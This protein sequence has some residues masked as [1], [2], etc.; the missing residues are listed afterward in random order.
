[1]RKIVSKKLRAILHPESSEVAKRVYRRAKK[2]YKKVPANAKSDYI[3]GLKQLF[4]MEGEQHRR[5][6]AEGE[7]EG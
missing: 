1:M 2:G 6:L 5:T 3:E 7:R 4:E